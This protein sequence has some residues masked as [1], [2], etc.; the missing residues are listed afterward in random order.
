VNPDFV[1]FSF[2]YVKKKQRCYTYSY[3]ICYSHRVTEIILPTRLC[4]VTHS[5][6]C[7]SDNR[8]KGECFFALALC[9]PSNRRCV[10]WSYTPW[11]KFRVLRKSGVLTWMSR[12]TGLRYQW[13]I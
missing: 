7:K 13:W 3:N 11:R 1:A 6:K 12:Y 5:E 2:I 4:T 8:R 10:L 9:R